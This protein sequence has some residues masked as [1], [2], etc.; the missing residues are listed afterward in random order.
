[1]TTDIPSIWLEFKS[2][3]A[4]PM[5]ICGV[6]REWSHN[7]DTTEASQVKQ[8]EK[9]TTQIDEANAC[10]EKIII[11]GDIN[12]CSNKWAEISYIRKNISRP[13]LEC[14]NQHGMSLA[15]IGTTYQA[16]HILNNGTIPESDLDHVYID[17]VRLNHQTLKTL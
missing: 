1:M 5:A 17:R 11:T 13:L 9:F 12:L 7:G 4:V 2:E 14:L 3:H 15:D 16:D 10:F 6:Y 8:I